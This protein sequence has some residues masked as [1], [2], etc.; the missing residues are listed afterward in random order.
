MVFWGFCGLFFDPYGP[1]GKFLPGIVLEGKGVVAF[2]VKYQRDGT[3]A[4]HLWSLQQGGIKN[5]AAS[6]IGGGASV[7][8]PRAGLAVTLIYGWISAKVASLLNAE[9]EP[10]CAYSQ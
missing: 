5:A 6:E 8:G 2:P 9:P 4:T 1:I 3:R 10:L 7:A